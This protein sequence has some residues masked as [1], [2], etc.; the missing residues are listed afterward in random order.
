ME[1]RQ[2]IPEGRSFSNNVCA[3]I[4]ACV[5]NYDQF[6]RYQA[7][8]TYVH[9]VPIKSGPLEHYQYILRYTGAVV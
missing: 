3:A 4:L 6:V 9:C 5:V 1:F 7:V 8:W 2:N